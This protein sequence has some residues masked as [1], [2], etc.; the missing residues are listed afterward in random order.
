M[1]ERDRDLKILLPLVT[2]EIYGKPCGSDKRI[3]VRKH[4]RLTGKQQ[5]K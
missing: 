4:Y 3:R 5:K 2:I 1:W